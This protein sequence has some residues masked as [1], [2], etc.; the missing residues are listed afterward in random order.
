MSNSKTYTDKEK[1]KWYK[2]ANLTELE[3]KYCRCLLEQADNELRRYGTLKQRSSWAICSSSITHK[4]Q[5]PKAKKDRK[6]IQKISLSGSCTK[7]LNINTVPTPL[8][9]AYSKLREKKFF[10]LLSFKLPSPK[11][12]YTNPE[13]YRTSLIIAIQEYVKIEKKKTFTSSEQTIHN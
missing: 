13:H 9:Y 5:S 6:E 1:E 3:K 8:L 11:N 10:N 2:G 12:F 4:K 7:F